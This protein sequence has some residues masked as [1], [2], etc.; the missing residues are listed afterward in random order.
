MVR[1]PEQ[2][3]ALK[4]RRERRAGGEYK[5]SAEIRSNRSGENS[6]MWGTHLTDEAKAILREAHLGKTPTDVTKAKMSKANSG[7]PSPNKGKT[8]TDVTKAKMREV[9]LGK[10]GPNLGKTFTDQT[11]A[12]M[13]KAHLGKPRSSEACGKIS[14]SVRKI[15]LD[16]QWYGVVTYTLGRIYCILFNAEFKELTGNIKVFLSPTRQ[17]KRIFVV[18]SLI[19]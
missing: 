10:P 6:P 7:K 11:K 14:E 5:L 8:H 15:W 18:E 13:S 1:T 19:D 2:K 12:K 3:E 4:I 16:K 9:K 17:K